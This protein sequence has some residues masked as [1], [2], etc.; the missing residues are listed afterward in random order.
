MTFLR[1]DTI[2]SKP[3]GEKTPLDLPQKSAMGSNG[4]EHLTAAA[5]LDGQ[6]LLSGG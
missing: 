1:K 2:R 5:E 6:I 4:T 3:W